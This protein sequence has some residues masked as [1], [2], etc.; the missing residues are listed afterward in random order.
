M[1][2]VV[3]GDSLCVVL[4]AQVYS[5]TH[6]HSTGCRSGG[7]L[8]SLRSCHNDLKSQVSIET[9]SG[10]QGVKCFF[11]LWYPSCKDHTHLSEFY[12]PSEWPKRNE[13]STVWAARIRTTE[14]TVPG[15]SW[16]RN[17]HRLMSSVLQWNWWNSVHQDIHVGIEG[18][19]AGNYPSRKEKATQMEK[20]TNKTSDPVTIPRCL[21][22]PDLFQ[23]F[24]C[25]R[26]LLVTRQNSLGMLKS[27]G[28]L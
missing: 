17:S 23:N 28:I 2:G 21:D 5:C 26:T 24:H 19:Q 14:A 7:K 12:S 15:T 22:L 11:G 6:T 3:S 8:Y 4:A 16:V 10:I 13:L 18:Q 1:Y 20:A 27:R 25:C 9:S